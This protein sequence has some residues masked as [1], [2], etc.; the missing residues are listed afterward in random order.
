[1]FADAC[2]G[3]VARGPVDTGWGD[4]TDPARSGV[5]VASGGRA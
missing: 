2:R 5:V 3:F 4:L 1:V